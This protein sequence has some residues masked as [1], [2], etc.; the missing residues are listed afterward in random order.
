[1]HGSRAVH[2]GGRWALCAVAVWAATWAGAGA[3]VIDRILAVVG[4]RPILLSDVRAATDL[5]FVDTA[6]ADDPIALALGHLIDRQL[7]LSEVERYGPAMPSEDAVRRAVDEI[8]ARVG[9]ASYRAALARGG[10]TD[11]AL[12]AVV[13]DTLRIDAYVSQRFAASAEPTDDEVA[14]AYTLRRDDLAVDGRV[15]TLSE[16]A[17][18]LRA[19][20]AEARRSA[21]VADWLE[22]LRRR[23]EVRLLHPAPGPVR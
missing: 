22:S 21:Q 10:L 12:A 16:A 3:E 14:R 15:P 1:M 23:T 20:L 19:E 2:R 8:A 6:G 11:A 17:P 9:E 13:R 18:T 4:G 5:G 7:M